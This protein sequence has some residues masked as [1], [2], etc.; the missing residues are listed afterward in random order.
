MVVQMGG[1]S[2]VDDAVW[3]CRKVRGR[4]KDAKVCPWLLAQLQPIL[5]D[6][7]RLMSLKLELNVTIDVGKR[8]VK[9]TYFLEGDG[10]LVFACYEKLS[11]VSQFCQAPHFS[12]VRAIAEKDP[13]QNVAALERKARLVLSWQLHDF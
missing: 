11:A 2:S 6:P 5:S 3:R 7:Q 10:P 13:R 9:A 12:N 1:V 4:G 8:F